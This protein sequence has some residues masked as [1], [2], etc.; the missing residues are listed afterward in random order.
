MNISVMT[1]QAEH[2]NNNGDQG[3][4]ELIE[5]LAARQRCSVTHLGPSQIANA[6]FVLIGDASRA[7]IRFYEPGLRNL[8]EGLALRRQ[9]GRPTLLVGSSYEFFAKDLGLAEPNPVKRQSD[10]VVTEFAGEK[11]VGYQNSD[12]DLP[13]LQ[14]E[15][16]FIATKLY[17]PVL[18]INPNLLER[19]SSGLGLEA[20]LPQDWL[21]QIEK[22]REKITAL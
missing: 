6:D 15:G 18:A 19:I 21:I 3:N 4:L 13:V 12:N 1:F 14:V 5:K 16:S 7:A 2:F 20:K 22:I 9:N 10:F 8:S 17:G 11:V